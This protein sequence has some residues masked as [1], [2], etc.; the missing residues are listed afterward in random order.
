MAPLPSSMLLAPRLKKE[1]E[2]LGFLDDQPA[3]RASEDFVGD[4]VDQKSPMFVI[5][6]PKYPP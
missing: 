4:L 5:T 1:R 2:L 3:F 6:H